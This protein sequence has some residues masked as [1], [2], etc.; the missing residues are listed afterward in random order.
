MFVI[1]YSFWGCNLQ[2]IWISLFVQQWASPYRL[3]GNCT[4]KELFWTSD[5]QPTKC[6]IFFQTV[7]LSTG[8]R[9]ERIMILVELYYG[10]WNMIIILFCFLP[11]KLDKDLYFPSRYMLI[12]EGSLS[13]TVSRKGREL[14]E[15]KPCW[16]VDLEKLSRSGRG[17][18]RNKQRHWL[19]PRKAFPIAV[20]EVNK[21]K[22][23][24]KCG[25][26]QEAC[27]SPS[28]VGTGRAKQQTA[29]ESHCLMKKDKENP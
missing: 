5:C 7:E 24:L 10:I 12:I 13:P 26:P 6:S 9:E 21:N 27:A 19:D 23:R 16:V 18:E 14:M 25:D 4:S 22:N 17:W 11:Q 3:D 29:A 2:C 1:R 8:D 20:L 28:S 15:G